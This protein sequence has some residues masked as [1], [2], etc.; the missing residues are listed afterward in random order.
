MKLQKSFFNRKN[1]LQVANDLVGKLIFSQ[2]DGLLTVA[3]IVE[4][5]GYSYK[6]RACHAHDN[7]YTE[8][9]KVMFGEPG[10]SYVYLCYGIHKL[11]NI[12]T[13]TS[14]IAEVVLVRAVEPIEGINIMLERRGFDKLNYQLTSGPGKLTASLGIEMI[15]NGIDLTGNV[16]WIEDDG[17]KLATAD[18]KT[19]A[20]IGVGYAGKDALLPWRFFL[21]KNPYVSKGRNEY[22]S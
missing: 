5:E 13:N 10:T 11:F 21:D 4:T 3:R 14:G 17:F 1:V 2:I 15:H 16:V 22:Y 12:V 8:R 7:K 19:S 18:I 9:T 6:E 20:R